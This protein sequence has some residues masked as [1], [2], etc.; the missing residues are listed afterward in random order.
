MP[1]GALP[2]DRPRHER[3]AVSL[4]VRDGRRRGAV[5]DEAEVARAR[6]GRGHRPRVRRRRGEL[7]VQARIAEHDGD[8]AVRQVLDRRAEHPLVPLRGALRVG[9]EQHGVV[10]PHCRPWRA[11]R[12]SA[13]HSG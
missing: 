7:H 10:E 1:R 9:G 6:P 11:S 5:P 12:T 3:H 13:T 2:V 8:A 4:Q